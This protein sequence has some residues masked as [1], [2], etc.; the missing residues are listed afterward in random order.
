MKTIHAGIIGAGFIGKAH[1]EAVRRL[2]FA[3]MA[4]LLGRDEKTAETKA[5]ELHIPRSYGSLDRFLADPKLEVVHVCTPNHLHYSMVKACLKAGKHVICEKP[6]TFT[7]RESR[8]LLEMASQAGLQHAIHFNYR[9]YPMIRQAKEMVGNGKIGKIYLAHGN[10]LQDWLLFDYD[11]N[12]RL[13]PERGGKVRAVADIGSHWCDLVQFVTG[14]Q[15]TEVLAD[16]STFLPQRKRPKAGRE[17]FAYAISQD[18]ESVA[19]ESEDAA[20]LLLR[21]SNNARGTL[22][23]SQVSSG[24]KNHLFFEINGSKASLTWNQEEPSKLWVGNR[25]KASEMWV[26]DPNLFSDPV[27]AFSRYPA[28]HPE[29]YADGITRFME[30]FYTKLLGRD[31]FLDFP[32]FADGLAANVLCERILESSKKQE[33]TRV[34]CE[35]EIFS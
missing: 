26:K 28:G 5:G 35:E 22:L 23:I 33:W 6:L 16:L 8:D 13:E 34:K 4:A 30:G 20:C 1:V 27:C 12:W 29:G 18:H 17:T 19:V 32:T 21:F 25:D 11:Y 7:S 24:R 2:G 9:S 10:Y 15:I 3:E 14:L 31:T